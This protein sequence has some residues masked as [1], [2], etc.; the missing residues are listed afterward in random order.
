MMALLLVPLAATAQTKIKP[1]FNLFS[2]Q[3]DVEIGQQSAAAAQQQLPLLND[4]QVNAYNITRALSQCKS[5]E[6]LLFSG[7]AFKTPYG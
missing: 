5:E 2:P 1:G 3:Q 7:G 4:A 6:A